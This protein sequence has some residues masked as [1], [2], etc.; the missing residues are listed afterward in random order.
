[1]MIS[2]SSHSYLIKKGKISWTS[3]TCCQATRNGWTISSRSSSSWIPSKRFGR[4]C[5]M[6]KSSLRT[7]RAKVKQGQI[8]S[9]SLAASREQ[10]HGI[11]LQV[12]HQTSCLNHNYWIN[13]KTMFRKDLKV[14]AHKS[15]VK[16]LKTVHQ[17]ITPQTEAAKSYL[18]A[19]K[20]KHSFLKCPISK[21]FRICEYRGARQRP[22]ATTYQK[23]LI[24]TRQRESMQT[25]TTQSECTISLNQ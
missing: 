5:R 18:A 14:R 25:Q 11:H 13:N 6:R 7:S 16:K 24:G 9:K 19:T 2:S 8:R 12:E 21:L 4:L 15:Q 23:V 1:M 17:M 10:A 20:L 3:S 22:T